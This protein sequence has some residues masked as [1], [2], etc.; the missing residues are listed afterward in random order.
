M[1][2]DLAIIAGLFLLIVFLLVF[3]QSFTSFGFTNPKVVSIFDK[4][5][6]KTTNISVK[7][8]NVTAEI[9]STPTARRNGLSKRESMPFNQ[10]MLFV[11]ENKAQYGIWMKD[12]KFAIDIIWLDENKR[13]V[14]IIA[15]VP[16]ESGKKDNQL[17]IYKPRTSALYIME[18]NA[19]LSD[20]NG[21][22][23]GDQVVSTL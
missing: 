5:K 15:N 7:S 2:K 9:A 19:G 10:G 20:L 3:G 12:M 8:L 21:L 6:V 23:I 16:P 1:K 13:I 22:Q 17:T 11:F 4:P 14:D 18:I